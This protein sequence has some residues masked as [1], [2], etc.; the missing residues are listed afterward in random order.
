MGVSDIDGVG[1]DGLAFVLQTTD[2][3][4]GS[5]GGGIGYAGLVNSVA[6]EFDTYH[7]WQVDPRYTGNH[8]GINLNGNLNSVVSQHVNTRMNNGG[9]W[10]AWVDYDGSSDLLEVRLSQTSERPDNPLLSYNIDLT[11]VFG[12]TD[13]F[14][15][16]TS[17]TGGAYGNHDILAWQFNDSYDPIGENTKVPEP[18]S[19]LALLA[20]GALGACAQSRKGK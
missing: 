12:S 18:N 8:V 16:F 6:I 15:G 14:V 9:I 11:S 3:T 19:V 1:A 17:A 4:V 5:V 7:N 13:V 20:V 10:S 2:N